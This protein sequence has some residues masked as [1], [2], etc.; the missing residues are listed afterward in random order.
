M[1]KMFSHFNLSRSII[2]KAAILLLFIAPILDG[3][4][5]PRLERE[6]KPD[7]IKKF[8]AVHPGKAKIYFY[9]ASDTFVA[10][11]VSALSATLIVNGIPAGTVKPG[12][13]LE[14]L[15]D[16]GQ[17]T[18]ASEVDA[19]WGIG[20]VQ[21]S[22]DTK[23]S[24]D[25]GKVSF[26]AVLESNNTVPARYAFRAVPASEGMKRVLSR[27]P[28]GDPIDFSRAYG[29]PQ[30]NVANTDRPEPSSTPN[31]SSGSD[32]LASLSYPTGERRPDD[33]AII[34][35]N[36]DYSAGSRDI[37]PVIPAQNDA[38]AM[39]RYATQALGISD[40]NIMLV[41][42]ATSTKMTELFGN[43]REYRGKLYDWVKPGISRVFIYYA[44]HGAPANDGSAVLVPVDSNPSALSISGYPLKLLYSNLSKL[45]T[46]NITVLLEACFS[47]IVEGGT[48]IPAAS[49]IL[50]KPKMANIPT[51]V[52]VLTAGAADQIASWMPDK[53]HGIFTEMFLR[54]MSG[55]ANRP[56]YGDGGGNVTMD[57]IEGFLRDKVEYT[58]RREWGRV[59]EVQ[60]IKGSG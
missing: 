48:V 50:I 59:Q 57:K 55:E 37:P 1:S 47:G 24:L 26:L 3:C 38:D 56:P 20:R 31:A 35:G 19:N 17:Y 36:S 52:T 4:S 53:R 30:T 51:N 45:P 25:A 12:N 60:V 42:N 43:D 7:N 16:E 28:I 11:L 6:I 40:S 29:E 44:G 33:I 46:T 2:G 23:V 54:G 9:V 5:G 8:T 39:K 49:P 34:I 14:V 13:Y 32:S 21:R 58:A 22:N 18:L 27:D 41:R 10:G 15:L